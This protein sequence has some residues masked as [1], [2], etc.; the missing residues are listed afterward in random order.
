MRKPLLKYLIKLSG[1]RFELN[2]IKSLTITWML[3]PSRIVPDVRRVVISNQGMEIA[4]PRCY[5][6]RPGRHWANGRVETQRRSTNAC[7][8]NTRVPKMISGVCITKEKGV[9][10]LL[11]MNDVI[12]CPLETRSTGGDKLLT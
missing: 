11:N 9:T 6:S 10:A 8:T 2:E 3:G 1:P 7:G 4:R 12:A 5:E